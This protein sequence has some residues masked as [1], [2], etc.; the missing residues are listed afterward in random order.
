M[1][2]QFAWS[3]QAVTAATILLAITGI[4]AALHRIFLIA[5]VMTPNGRD[6]FQSVFAQPPLLTF[7]HVAPG[8]LFMVLG[9]LQF[10][11]RIRSRHIVWHRWSGRVFLVS[12]LLVGLTA[13]RMAFL[14]PI[15]GLSEEVAAAIFASLFLFELVKAYVHIRR[16]EIAQ[17]REWMIRAFAIGLAVATMRPMVAA[18]LVFSGLP[19][20]DFFGTVFWAGFTIHAI[21]AEV[22]INCTRTYA[23]QS[24][25][26]NP[27]HAWR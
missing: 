18:F 12:A 15:S 14:K 17:H 4:V 10:V 3:M 16:R 24:I 2:K 11:R 20:R 8:F 6:P 25:I 26:A 7:L 19:I 23:G 1:R 13:L 27:D 22:W 9:P 5:N 21:A